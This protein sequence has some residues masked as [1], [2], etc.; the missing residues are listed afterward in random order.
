MKHFFV[1]LLLS[2]LIQQAISNALGSSACK[3]GTSGLAALQEPKAALSKLS[4]ELAESQLLEEEEGEEQSQAISE[5]R[6]PATSPEDAPSEKVLAAASSAHGGESSGFP[7]LVD[8]PTP[9]PDVLVL[10]VAFA[11]FKVAR[12]FWKKDHS[13]A[14]S[15]A[16]NRSY[17]KEATDAFGCTELHIAAAKGCGLE[18]RKLLEG[19]SDPNAR[20]AWDE[21]P[22]H[23]AARSGNV[24]V[25]EMLLQGGADLDARNADERTP[26]VT[27]AEEKQEA[28]CKY[29][30]DQGAKTGGMEDKQLPQLLS[31][32]L[33][34]QL[35][36]QRSAE[37]QDVAADE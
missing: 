1:P 10:L 13:Q 37:Q 30:L 32:L 8:L 15:E 31:S 22:L 6:R 5:P 2:I 14:C 4:E 36:E 12:C 24:E 27:A 26:L 17:R 3:G 20:E 29:L 28:V 33:L 16:S 34:Q 35:L 9:L 25:A 19:R 23:M 11:A 21:T 18:V 7:T